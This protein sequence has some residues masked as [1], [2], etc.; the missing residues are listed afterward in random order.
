MRVKRSVDRLPAHLRAFVV[1]QAEGLY[2]PM[3]HAGWRYI[4]RVSRDF[5]KEHAHQK[6]LDGLTETGISVESIPRIDE[7]DL[8]LSQFGWGAVPVSG[9]I[10]PLVFMELLS[11][12]ILPI[13]ADMRSPGHLDY[14]PSPDIVHEAAGHAP[15]VADPEYAAFLHETGEIARKCIIT[16]KDMDQY[17]AILHL[18]NV[19]EDPRSTK[20]QIAEAEERLKAA[21][22]ANDFVSE[23]AKFGRFIWWTV[24]YGLIG[25]L[26]APKIYGAGLLSSVAESYNCLSDRVKKL[27]LTLDCLNQAY[28][29]TE[30]QPQLF[31]TP[32]F[33][34]L[35]QVARE[36]SETLAYRRGG[37]YGLDEAVRAEYPV[38]VEL[39]MGIQIAGQLASYLK[40]ARGE[41]AYLKFAGPCQIARDDVEL[42]GQ[43]TGRHPQGFGAPVGAIKGGRPRFVPGETVHL[44]YES[45]VVV[46]GKVVR[47]VDGDIVTLADCTVTYG[48]EN[49]YKPEWGEYDLVLGSRVESVAGG[50]ADRA[51]YA[52]A[53]TAKYRARKPASTLTPETKPLCTLY[54]WVRRLREEGGD[55]GELQ[56][57]L[58]ELDAKFPD[59][60]LLRLEILELDPSGPGSK[61]IRDHLKDLAARKPATRELIQRGMQLMGSGL[62]HIA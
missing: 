17:E 2:T 58:A 16:R 44:E 48:S 37:N 14:T 39:D 33:L 12:G 31:V 1:E 36:F 9:F 28:D 59:D 7:M 6:Y 43:G 46:D 19:K 55:L 23:A 3:D 13:A 50:A 4:L 42:E 40:D 61:R 8:C 25:T 49:L 22:A 51:K 29:I 18:S 27:P 53:D 60:W 57:V 30:P 15:I 52:S 5:F 56:A 54:A 45:G 41:A 38:T 26:E 32:D 10:P 24:E 34:T 62:R 21:T 35:S 47:S 11:M 20:A